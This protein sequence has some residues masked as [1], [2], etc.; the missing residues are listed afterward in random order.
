MAQSQLK[1][2]AV[3][4]PST[5][6]SK[7]DL[8]NAHQ[9]RHGHQHFHQH[10]KEVRELQELAKAKEEK[11]EIT[12]TIN[13]KVVS[14]ASNSAAS[15]AATPAPASVPAQNGSIPTSGG[16]GGGAAPQSQQGG[17]TAPPSGG[18]FGAGTWNQAG[19]YDSQAQILTNLVFLNN[20]GD[21]SISGTWD[22]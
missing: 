21:P 1:K 9:R 10:N 4:Y 15:A 14:W 18:S 8:S 5:G 6:G 3:Y 12:A 7:R 22:L 2:F 17:S 19:L 13:G 11:R 20:K 16:S